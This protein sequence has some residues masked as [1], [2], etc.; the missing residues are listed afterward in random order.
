MNQNAQATPSSTRNRFD[1]DRFDELLCADGEKRPI[2][3]WQPPATQPTTGVFLAI[4]GGLAHAGDYCTYAEAFKTHGW[5]T[6]SFDMRGHNRQTR[7]DI[8][9]FDDFLDDLECF[10]DWTHNAFPSLP[11]YV[12]GH[13][14]GGLI[15]ARYA[16]DSQR[17]K[18]A[19]KGYI[20]S[21][22][23]WA[24]A[25][26][27]PAIMQLFAGVIAKLFPTLKAPI[28]DFT[29]VLTHDPVITARHRQDEADHYRASEGTM[30]F[31]HQLMS[32][33]KKLAPLMQHWDAPL[34]AVVAGDDKLSD[35]NAVNDML[36]TI[37]QQFLEN[38]FYA[39]NYHENF[40]ETNRD[41][42]YAKI[43][44]WVTAQESDD[45]SA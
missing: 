19:I 29:D 10:L 12:V 8:M 15:A 35:A 3:I 37:P 22:P 1:E 31:A 36:N 32:A 11:I 7:A 30:R 5:A 16:L 27:M 9:H 2:H 25:V 43:L 18:T 41:E 23:Y 34:F 39:D 21:S 44:N 26:P 40:N 6:V 17:K 45:T 33:Q 28:E 42:I 20:L 38:H 4:H 24:N 13:S 14:M